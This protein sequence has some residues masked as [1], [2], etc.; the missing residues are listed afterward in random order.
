MDI[1]YVWTGEHLILPGGGCV[2]DGDLIVA[3][4]DDPL[5]AFSLGRLLDPASASVVLSDPRA[6]LRSVAV[7]TRGPLSNYAPTDPR[8]LAIGAARMRLLLAGAGRVE[9]E[10][11]G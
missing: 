3:R 8:L 10:P 5:L 7:R 2:V 6:V 11:A 1:R 9:T 4:P